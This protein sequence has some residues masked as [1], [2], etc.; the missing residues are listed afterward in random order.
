MSDE[1]QDPDLLDQLVVLLRPNVCRV[2]TAR[3]NG[4]INSSEFME[5]VVQD[6]MERN[7]GLLVSED[8]CRKAIDDMTLEDIVTFDPH[9]NDDKCEEPE[10]SVDIT[11]KASE[12]GTFEI[13]SNDI[14]AIGEFD[15]TKGAM[16]IQRGSLI[17][18][19][20]GKSNNYPNCRRIHEHLVKSDLVETDKSGQLKTLADID[21]SSASL[22]ASLVLGRSSASTAW[23]DPT[24]EFSLDPKKTR[25]P[26]MFQV[27][28]NGKTYRYT[29]HG[30]RV[31]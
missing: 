22:A 14:F 31:L 28:S 15:S 13:T 7:P 9:T 8:M 23:K 4:V 10:G 27:L 17:S 11:K 1:H 26:S 19:D 24:G 25:K 3:V 29:E 6:M 12:S 20:W 16:V 2:I 30:R 5:S 21:V 18:R